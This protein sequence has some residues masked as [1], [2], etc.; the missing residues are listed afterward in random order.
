MFRRVLREH[1]GSRIIIILQAT[2]GLDPLPGMSL[3]DH[4]PA[5]R[6]LTK[7]EHRHRK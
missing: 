2:G 3:K 5:R 1:D 6:G 7:V 4:I